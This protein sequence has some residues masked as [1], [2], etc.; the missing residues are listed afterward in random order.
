MINKNLGIQL[1]D[2]KNNTANHWLLHRPQSE[3]VI[4]PPESQKE[5][6]S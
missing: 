6:V 4:L 2:L 5:T 3:M 1:E